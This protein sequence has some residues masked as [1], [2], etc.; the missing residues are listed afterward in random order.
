[1]KL[2]VTDTA[3]KTSQYVRNLHSFPRSVCN[4]A[5]TGSS[6]FNS[7]R[8]YTTCNT[9]A[10]FEADR[11]PHRAPDYAV[12]SLS[13]GF[14]LPPVAR[15]LGA[16]GAAQIYITRGVLDGAPNS[17]LLGAQMS[18]GLGL[19]GKG[20]SVGFGW[21]GP[22]RPRPPAERRCDLQVHQRVHDP[23][24]PE[25]GDPRRSGLA[26]SRVELH[27]QPLGPV[28][29]PRGRRVLRRECRL[30][31][32]HRRSMRRPTQ[33]RGIRGRGLPETPLRDLEHRAAETQPHDRGRRPQTTRA[34]AR[35]IRSQPR[36]SRRRRARLL[37]AFNREAL[38]CPTSH[39]LLVYTRGSDATIN[40]VAEVCA[41]CAR[42]LLRYSFPRRP[43]PAGR[44]VLSAALLL[45]SPRAIRAE[46]KA[47]LGS[48]FV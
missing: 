8:G 34:V 7:F 30:G 25:R 44:A 41:V 35:R 11:G 48:F 27:L 43:K 10:G 31:R 46:L 24:R 1:M 26:R 36:P 18:V 6:A 37:C 5:E 42:F 17:V 40:C 32:Q 16:L 12:I 39:R 22:P 20:A 28:G 21:V 2:T 4:G 47:E 9:R 38:F 15:G 14:D 3:G 45:R 29:T 13:G 23:R 33:R 19:S